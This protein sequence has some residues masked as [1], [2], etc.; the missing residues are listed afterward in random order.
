MKAH[1]EVNALNAR[2]K[3]LTETAKKIAEQAGFGETEMLKLVGADH[4]VE[5]PADAKV[6]DEGDVRYFVWGKESAAKKV[7]KKAKKK[8]AKKKA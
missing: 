2:V 8:A 3:E 6:L 5:I 1:E 7:V 4:G